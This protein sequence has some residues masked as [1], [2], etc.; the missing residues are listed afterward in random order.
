MQYAWMHQPCPCPPSTT[1]HFFHYHRSIS[2]SPQLFFRSS[3][4]IAPPVLICH[5]PC[6]T[7]QSTHTSTPSPLQSVHDMITS[8]TKSLADR[9]HTDSR[10]ATSRIESG[11]NFGFHV[12]RRTD[13]LCGIVTGDKAYP[14][15][16]ARLPRFS[17]GF[18]TRGCH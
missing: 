15:A 16:L 10:N 13:G 12:H 18:C 6:H 11:V 7:L 3:M 2:S 17:T 8:V 4:M 5:P 14:A 9:A 1:F